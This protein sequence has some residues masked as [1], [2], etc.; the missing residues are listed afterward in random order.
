MSNAKKIIGY[1]VRAHDGREVRVKWKG[2]LSTV[3]DGLWLQEQG[4]TCKG[5]LLTR[6]QAFKVAA[7]RE[8]DGYKAYIVRVVRQESAK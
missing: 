7:A 3:V 2:V 4:C 8:E 6:A 1:R 5:P